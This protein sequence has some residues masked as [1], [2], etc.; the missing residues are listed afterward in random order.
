MPRGLFITGTDTHVG[1]TH[2]AAAIA[3]KLHAAGHC[4][5]V[6]KPVASGCELSSKGGKAAE[7]ISP[8]A[9]AL[10]RGAGKPLSLEQVC[11]QRF[12]APLAPHLA[13][14]EEGKQVDRMLLRRGLEPWLNAS[15]VVII[16]GAGGLFSPIADHEL[17][18]EL[19]AEIGF[20]V[21]IVAPNRLGVINQALQTA[22]AGRYFRGGLNLAGVVLNQPEPLDIHADPSQASNFVELQRWCRVAVFTELP[23]NSQD[24]APAVDWWKLA[25]EAT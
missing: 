17:V 12:R 5:G 15:E 8:D 11:P 16:E 21:V 13:A 1:K 2:V 25:R 19:A 7:L 24:F 6:Y 4:V 23:H 9:V 22:I 18:A 20:P 14:R 10:W 3:A